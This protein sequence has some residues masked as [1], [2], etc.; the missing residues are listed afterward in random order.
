MGAGFASPFVSC[1][2]E[3]VFDGFLGPSEGKGV[4]SAVDLDNFSS[5]GGGGGWG[6]AASSGR[7]CG[8]R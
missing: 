1:S 4:A 5:V 6:C 3:H 7:G 8:G 2:F